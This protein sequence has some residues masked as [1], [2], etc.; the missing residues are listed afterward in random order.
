MTRVGLFRDSA[1]LLL[2]G[3]PWIVFDFAVGLLY[4][5]G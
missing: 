2:I 3:S 1:P 4:W 5:E